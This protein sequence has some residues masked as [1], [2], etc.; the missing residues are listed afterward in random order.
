MSLNR[1]IHWS[2]QFANGNVT[3]VFVARR[4]QALKST[5]MALAGYHAPY[6][7]AAISLCMG[8]QPFGTK[9]FFYLYFYTVLTNLFAYVLILRAGQITHRFLYWQTVFQ[10][11]VWLIM[12]AFY[13][14]LMAEN[15]SVALIFAMMTFVFV[16]LIGSLREGLTL[17]IGVVLSYLFVVNVGERFFGQPVNVV[18][19]TV[20][21]GAFLMVSLYLTMMG[22]S[23]RLS[24]D[25]ARDT[26]LH[27]QKA[28][29]E[30]N[31]AMSQLERK[32]R[33]DELTGL[34]NRRQGRETLESIQEKVDN[35]S[36]KA[37]LMLLDIDHFK[38]INDQH[39]H[40]IGDLVLK[41]VADELSKLKRDNDMLARWGGEEFL[42][43]WP[44]L[45]LES[46]IRVAERLRVAIDELPI[47]TGA[48]SVRVSFS[49]GL[50]EMVPGSDPDSIIK[51]ADEYL[52]QAKQS[53]RNRV[54]GPP[55]AQGSK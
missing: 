11:V 17:C 38:Q 52:Y 23:M 28:Q 20:S 50:A 42:I 5:L 6:F 48:V 10:L 15:R 25:K 18:S 1:F 43:A 37:T 47:Q 13:A 34:D 53:G 19:E 12:F 22:R 3:G 35:G 31:V 4:R 24:R 26:K 2:E 55:V 16:A 32:A 51:Q 54:C 36:I 39:G 21:L 33:T 30:L 41:K 8:F 40:D 46:S 27:L 49:A 29:N 14:L 9:P 44:Q 45:S 7:I